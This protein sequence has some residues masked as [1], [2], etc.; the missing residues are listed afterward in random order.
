MEAGFNNTSGCLSDKLMAAMQGAKV[1]GADS[2][3]TVEGTSSLSAFL[4]VAKPTDSPSALY[5]DLNI[6]ATP[7]G[8]DP[9]D[10][11]QKSYDNWKTN[12]AHNC[13]PVGNVD[14]LFRNADFYIYPNPADD[15]LSIETGVHHKNLRVIVTDVVGREIYN[16]ALA[17]GR[18]QLDISAWVSGNYLLTIKYRGEVI[19]R[20]ITKK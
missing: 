9:I 6:G 3:C 4:R 7:T 20:K 14:L 19:V 12:S 11:L 2:R 5:I 10:E 8:I 17:K 18:N 15:I 13:Y 16:A 1:I